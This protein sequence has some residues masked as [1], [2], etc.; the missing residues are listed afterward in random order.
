VKVLVAL[1]LPAALAAA[2]S[3]WAASVVG[4]APVIEPPAGSVLWGE[5]YFVEPELLAAWLNSRG[6][7]YRVW[8]RRHPRAAARQQ[9]AAR[10]RARALR[11]DSPNG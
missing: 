8:A 5:Q 11:A 6:R 2:L 1:G 7:S 9:A 3:I 10:A 4:Q